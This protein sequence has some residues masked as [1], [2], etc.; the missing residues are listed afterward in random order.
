ME[1]GCEQPVNDR[2]QS[3][4]FLLFRAKPLRL[5]FTLLG[6]PVVR[7]DG[8]PVVIKPESRFVVRG[9]LDKPAKV[10][11]GIAVSYVNGEFAG[12][13]RGDL[14]RQQPISEP[15]ADG[16]FRGRLSNRRLYTR[17]VRS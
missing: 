13:F 12:K 11:F 16:Q 17:S 14:D 5:R 9:R 3:K 8:S 4:P 2:R 15:D 1:S 10:H 6:L 7:S